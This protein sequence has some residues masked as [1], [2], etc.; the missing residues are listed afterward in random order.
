LLSNSDRVKRG[1]ACDFGPRVA[2]I[3]I[4]I[5]PVSREQSSGYLGLS[6]AHKWV[7]VGENGWKRWKLGVGRWAE[8]HALSLRCAAMSKS[9]FWQMMLPSFGARVLFDHFRHP[10]STIP[11]RPALES[12][13]HPIHCWT[14]KECNLAIVH[15][16]HMCA[17][18]PL[19]GF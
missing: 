11:S 10:T 14:Q 4:N 16:V 9:L 2:I 13:V 8:G 12:L 18:L 1:W 3:M 5:G 7:K 17:K 15:C 19:T 6:H